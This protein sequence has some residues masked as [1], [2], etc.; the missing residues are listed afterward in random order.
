GQI[1]V[2][3]LDLVEPHEVPRRGGQ[4]GVALVAAEVRRVVGRQVVPL[5]A[6]HL[7]GLAA[8][9]EV[10]V[11][12]LGDLGGVAAD[13][14]RRRRRGRLAAD[15]EPEFGGHAP[16][17]YAFSTLTRKPLN[18]GVS[19]LAISGVE[20]NLPVLGSAPRPAAKCQW[21]GIPTW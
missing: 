18:S 12:E 1:A 13:A 6:G 5:L 17:P 8:D 20:L 2:V 21:T 19:R 10:D 3:E 14:G 16:A 9:A 7:A 15:G 11:D 4:V